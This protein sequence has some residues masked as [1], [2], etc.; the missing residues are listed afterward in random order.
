MKYENFGRYLLRKPLFSNQLLFENLK[1]KN[2]DDLVNELI[3]NNEFAVS[4]YWSSPE[5]YNL[6]INYRN[7]D[8]SEK[9]KQDSL[10]F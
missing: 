5:L 4:I 8:I 7:N 1:T 9:R 2:L 3:D 6:I 10:I